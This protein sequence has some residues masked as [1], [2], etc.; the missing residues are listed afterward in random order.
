MLDAG[1]LI[2]KLLL[3]M[4]KLLAARFDEL[5]VTYRLKLLTVVPPMLN[6]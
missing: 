6:G 1:R 5:V 2:P 3:V 4:A